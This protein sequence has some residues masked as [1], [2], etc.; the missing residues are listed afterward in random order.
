MIN[1]K[2][3]RVTSYDMLH[4]K[5]PF[6]NDCHMNGSLNGSPFVSNLSLV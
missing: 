6:L 4:F 1:L 3:N 5:E 2:M